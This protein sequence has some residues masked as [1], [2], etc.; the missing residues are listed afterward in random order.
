MTMMTMIR[1]LNMRRTAVLL[2]V[3]MLGTP[4]IAAAQNTGSAVGTI[5]IAHGGGPAWDAQVVEV[6]KQVQ[7]GGPV[8]VSFLMGPGAATAR[9]QDAARKLV[10]AGAQQI[11]VV[12]MLV[13]SHSG[14]Y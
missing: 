11:V 7:T 4:T 1:E 3:L 2:S 14:H 9:F 5:V 10:E 6:V 12:P 13:S 8:E